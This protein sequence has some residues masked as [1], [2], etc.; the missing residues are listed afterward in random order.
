MGGKALEEA[1]LDF[2]A[3]YQTV[4]KEGRERYKKSIALD[5]LSTQVGF[6]REIATPNAVGTILLFINN[7]PNAFDRIEL[8][9]KKRSDFEMYKN[10]LQQYAHTK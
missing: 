2:I 7:W 10:I 5:A 6:P 1:S 9:V 4:L 3:C 8:F